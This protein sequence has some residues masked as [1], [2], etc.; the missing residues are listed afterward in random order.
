MPRARMCTASSNPTR[1]CSGTSTR[2]SGDG[3]LLAAAAAAP[4]PCGCQLCRP[5]DRAADIGPD[6]LPHL[7]A[8]GGRKAIVEAGINPGHRDLLGISTQIGEPMR[9]AGSEWARHGHFGDVV[10]AEH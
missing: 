6:L 4:L 5:Q 3:P 7:A 10:G 2:I 1:S 8:D 9:D